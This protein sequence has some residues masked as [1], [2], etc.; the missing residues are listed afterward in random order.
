MAIRSA[1]SGR[2]LVTTGDPRVSSPIGTRIV[3]SQAAFLG[4][5]AVCLAL[6]PRYL[7]S[8]DEGGISNFGVHAATVVPF[9]FAF[10]AS[11][12]LLWDAARRL[13]SSTPRARRARAGLVAV[14]LLSVAVLAST[15]PYRHGAVLRDVHVVVAG[16]A[17]LAQVAL[18][19]WVAVRVRPNVATRGSFAL[20]AAAAVLAVLTLPGVVH[21]LFV[22]QLIAAIAFA[23]LL[24]AWWWRTPDGGLGGPLAPPRGTAGTRRAPSR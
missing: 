7:T 11:G 13:E 18:G 17:V 9:T 21:V 5:L 16:V 12:A 19:A 4:G 2:T 10:L 23:S 15:Y 8:S 1:P 3:L 6:Q 14:A 24:V 20:L 22:A